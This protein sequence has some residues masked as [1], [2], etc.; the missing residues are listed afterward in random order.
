VKR[1]RSLKHKNLCGASLKNVRKQHNV[2]LITL[3]VR[4]EEEYGVFISR[5][6]LGRIE[7]GIRAVSDYELIAIASILE[8]DVTAILTGEGALSIEQFSRINMVNSQENPDDPRTNEDS[9]RT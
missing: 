4:L 9:E 7:G 1:R 6:G 3:S 2:D 8:V 5:S